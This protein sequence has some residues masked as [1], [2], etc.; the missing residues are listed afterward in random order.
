MKYK[1]RKIGMIRIKRNIS[2]PQL[3]EEMGL[4]LTGIYNIVTGI[5]KNPWET[6]EYKI[7]RWLSKQGN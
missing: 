4:S 2:Y 3:A 6:T 7:D 5:T 1:Y